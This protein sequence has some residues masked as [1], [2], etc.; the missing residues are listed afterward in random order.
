MRITKAFLLAE[1]QKACASQLEAFALTYP[2]GFEVNR[3]N[4]AEA[5]ERGF[6]LSWVLEFR[7][8]AAWVRFQAALEPAEAAYRAEREVIRAVYAAE[9]API[10][11]K[12]AAGVAK[13]A[14]NPD[15]GTWERLRAELGPVEQ[16]N[17]DRFKVASARY[18]AVHTEQLILACLAVAEEESDANH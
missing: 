12:Y 15:E 10:M 13:P 7:F 5:L 1:P 11:A 8:A 2:D 3:E 6:D 17:H 14:E 4:L 16:A 18:A 9:R